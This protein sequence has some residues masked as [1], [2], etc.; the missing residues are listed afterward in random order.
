MDHTILSKIIEKMFE[1]ASDTNFIG[2]IADF[3]L[4]VLDEYR[5]GLQVSDIHQ[6]PIVESRCAEKWVKNNFGCLEID[7][8]VL[9]GLLSTRLKYE[10]VFS[11]DEEFLKELNL[12]D[13]N[14]LYSEIDIFTYSGREYEALKE[15]DSIRVFKGLN[16]GIA[17]LSV[18]S[19]YDIIRI[20]S[21]ISIGP[22]GLVVPNK[23]VDQSMEDSH[24]LC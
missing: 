8:Q 3:E 23:R 9:Y 21:V 2:E 10:I 16:V 5:S 1:D 19:L 20:P 15:V 11:S 22:E 12:V 18:G 17:L 14:K 6:E 24:G 4:A 13:S 7:R